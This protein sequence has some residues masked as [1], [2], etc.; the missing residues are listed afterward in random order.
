MN[1]FAAAFFVL[2]P[3]N[4]MNNANDG[5]GVVTILLL[6]HNTDALA[7]MQLLIKRYV[8]VMEL[9]KEDD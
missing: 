1:R 6:G 5:N 7:N 2:T 4:G 8:G 3:R 9:I